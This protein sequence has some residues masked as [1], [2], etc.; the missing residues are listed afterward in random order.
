M[1]DNDYISN[2][3]NDQMQY[4]HS[5]CIS[6]QQEFYRLSVVIIVAN[7]I[8]PVLLLVS[9]CGAIKYIVAIISALASIL[10]SILLLRN[11]KET[12]LEY[13]STYEKLKREKILFET[14]SGVYNEASINDFILN[15]ENIIDAEH[16]IWKRINSNSNLKK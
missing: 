1:E 3:L 12:W 5:K 2:R 6:F 14:K 16:E 10:S 7:A 8:I 4:Y 11:T 9:N 15:C 13:R